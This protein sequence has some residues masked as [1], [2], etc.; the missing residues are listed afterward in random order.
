MPANFVQ[1]AAWTEYEFKELEYKFKFHMQG[2]I[3]DLMNTGIV[4]FQTLQHPQWDSASWKLD[5]LKKTQPQKHGEYVM[6]I[7]RTKCEEHRCI[8]SY[9]VSGTRMNFSA[10]RGCTSSI[11]FD[12]CCH[13]PCT[14]LAQRKFHNIMKSCQKLPVKRG[15]RFK[16]FCKHLSDQQTN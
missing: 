15:L 3:T 14:A 11:Y 6:Y 12:V 2:L 4:S 5:L 13:S 8:S 1:M 16:E 10:F 7:R 9:E